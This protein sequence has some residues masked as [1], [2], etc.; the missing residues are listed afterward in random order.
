M[1]KLV[2][3]PEW[4]EKAAQDQ[5]VAKNHEKNNAILQ[6]IRRMFPE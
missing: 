3:K 4:K 6:D 1:K 2:D 5:E